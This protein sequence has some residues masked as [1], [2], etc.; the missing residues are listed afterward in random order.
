MYII[1]KN[2]LTIEETFK[3]TESICLRS[4]RLLVQLEFLNEMHTIL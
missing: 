2:R 4:L 3:E 1:N